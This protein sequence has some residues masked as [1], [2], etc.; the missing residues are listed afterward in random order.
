MRV[1]EIGYGFV[2]LAVRE[3]GKIAVQ[4]SVNRDGTII[5]RKMKYAGDDASARLI[6]R[7]FMAN[8]SQR[9]FNDDAPLLDR[10]PSLLFRP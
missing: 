7:Q 10:P 3:R 1:D 4:M 5:E 9:F 2:I 8:W 6:A